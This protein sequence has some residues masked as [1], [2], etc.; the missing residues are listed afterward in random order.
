M[1]TI[2]TATTYDPGF[3][4][5]LYAYLRV[6]AQYWK[7][8]AG[9][10]G[11]LENYNAANLALYSP[12]A[13]YLAENGSSGDYRG[14]IDTTAI[15]NGLYELVIRLRASAGAVPA[16]GDEP[17]EEDMVQLVAGTIVGTGGATSP[18]PVGAAEMVAKIKAALLAGNA[19][20]T[21][22]DVDGQQVTWS[23][24]DAIEELQFWQRQAAQEAGTRPRASII[25]LDGF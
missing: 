25:R 8:G 14:T 10:N 5:Q 15:P 1:S 4:T 19:T 12:A 17:V 22:M 23:R 21:M 9:V 7:P 2:A 13:N 11:S 6:G 3:G 24:R 16:E 20:V 18:P